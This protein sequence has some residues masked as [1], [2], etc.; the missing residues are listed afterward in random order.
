MHRVNY[1][2][3]TTRL[4]LYNTNF[5]R[6]FYPINSLKDFQTIWCVEQILFVTASVSCMADIFRQ[7]LLKIYSKNLEHVLKPLT[8]TSHV[9]DQVRFKPDTL[10][11]LVQVEHPFPFDFII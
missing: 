11:L 4:K 7:I 8:F 10:Q 5:E 6:H 1:H 9:F 3:T 2:V